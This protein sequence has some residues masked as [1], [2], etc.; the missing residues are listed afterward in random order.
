MSPSMK[1]WDGSAWQTTTLVGPKG[2]VGPAGVGATPT[3]PASGGLTG[4]FP[5]PGINRASSGGLIYAQRVLGMNNA[6]R[7]GIVNGDTCYRDAGTG[8]PLQISYQPDVPVWWDLDF[9]IGIMQKLDAAYHYLIGQLVLT[10]ADQDG[11]PGI[12]H[13]DTQHASVQTYVK[14]TGAG[15]FRLAANTFYTAKVTFGLNGGSW[16]YHT[17]PNYLWL[18]GRVWPQ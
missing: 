6:Y 9:G 7:A 11:A 2:D 8:N 12:L 15:W 17:G 10:P 5:N 4:T 18:C 16:Q 1:V 14:R 3:G 13:Y